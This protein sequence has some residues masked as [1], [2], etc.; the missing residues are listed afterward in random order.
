MQ[1]VG[2][3]ELLNLNITVTFKSVSKEFLDFLG[4]VFA[5]EYLVCCQTQKQ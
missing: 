4:L 5:Q 2:A 1:P 3:C